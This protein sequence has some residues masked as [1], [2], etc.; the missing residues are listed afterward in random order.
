MAELNVKR[1]QAEGQSV[2]RQGGNE[3]ANWGNRDPFFSWRPSDFF[4]DPFS[5]MRRMREEMDRMLSRSFGEEFA[6]GSAV[7]SPLIEVR[8]QNG[9]LQVHA[10]LPG[11]KPEDVRIEL[12]DDSLVIQGERKYEHEDKSEGVFRSERRYGKFYRQIPLPEGA[13]ADQ[14]K[15]QFNNGVLE[16]TVPVPERK[17]NRRQIPIATGSG[18]HAAAAV[19]EQRK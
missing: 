14:V 13:N 7:W 15:A 4:N 16:V 8:E 3:L 18:E 2:T 5:V 19:T 1:N 10:E 17:S 11:L 9:K 12:A 6:G